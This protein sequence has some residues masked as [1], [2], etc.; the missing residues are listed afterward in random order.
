MKRFLLI[1]VYV[2]AVNYS[3]A[4]NAGS[5]DVSFNGT[6]VVYD[7]CCNSPNGN[8]DL[9]IQADQKIVVAT[10]YG[11][12]EHAR[13]VRYN[14][15][16]SRDL[17]FGNNGLV[18]LDSIYMVSKVLQQPDGKLIICGT[19]G[20][21]FPTQFLI[22]MLRL[23]A[24]GSLDNSFNQNGV[25]LIDIW[26]HN[27]FLN[28]A[29]LQ[30]D[31]KIVFAGQIYKP[32]PG[33]LNLALVGR[34]TTDGFLDTTFAEYNLGWDTMRWSGFS[35]SA[36]D[37][38]VSSDKVVLTG[39]SQTG[40]FA[41]TMVVMQFNS[42]GLV[43]NSFGTNGTVKHIPNNSASGNYHMA[44]QS[45]GKILVGGYGWNGTS[46]TRDLLVT[47]FNAN[48]TLDNSF[49]TN[50]NAF[51]DLGLN[52]EVN[53]LALQT[54]GRIVLAGTATDNQQNISYMVARFNANGTGDN[55]FGM[56]GILVPLQDPNNTILRSV[57]L[58]SDNRILTAG[59]DNTLRLVVMRFTP[60]SVGVEETQSAR[61]DVHL[62]PNPTNGSFTIDGIERMQR[63]ELVN[64]TGQTIY[65]SGANKNSSAHFIDLPQN[66]QS[67][68]YMLRVVTDD[69][70]LQGNVVVRR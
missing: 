8:M 33:Q 26:N 32:F 58:H 55:T 12:N 37:V 56:N 20:V 1:A 11:W 63:I 60:G 69:G 57:A 29:A 3:F 45:D 44:I 22:A 7:T 4:Q 25:L 46:T 43:D 34:V 68:F 9:M 23:N 14:W 51:G 62:F 21:N 49:G 16:G 61:A 2:F 38:A 35:S 5:L 6:G 64:I 70:V 59:L 15:D 48:G 18:T 54:D 28:A 31:G 67:G 41:D 42:N 30:P 19:Y 66:V 36:L 40:S 24:N 27:Q 52:E 13:V 39:T 10:S 65:S 50:G 53:D 47:R 17:T